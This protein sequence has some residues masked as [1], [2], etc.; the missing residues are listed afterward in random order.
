MLRKI[1]LFILIIIPCIIST[2][3]RACDVP[4]F[5]YALE[6]WPAATYTLTASTGGGLSAGQG[7]AIARCRELSVAQDLK[8]N[9]RFVTASV[10]TGES[11][12]MLTYPLAG[13]RQAEIWSGPL[14]EE[15]AGRIAVSPAREMIARRLLDGQAVVWVLLE[16]GDNDRDQAAASLLEI[17][18]QKLEKSLS[19]P[20]ALSGVAAR[21]LPELKIDFSLVRVSRSDPDEQVLVRMLSSTEPDLDAFS[22][23]PMAFPVFGRARVLYAL[24]GEGINPET[25]SRACAFLVGPCACEIK[26]LTPGMDLLVAADWQSAVRQSWVNAVDA[27]PLASLASLAGRSADASDGERG[28]FGPVFGILAAVAAVLAVVVIVSIRMVRSGRNK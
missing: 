22:G 4:V 15:N 20:E 24:V 10:R 9:L 18:L 16:S 5:R 12:L 2:Q 21:D 13:G 17:E 8:A 6:R 27:L 3:L 28:V 25:V 19:L 7:E 23:Q 26:D 11:R 1:N 14:T